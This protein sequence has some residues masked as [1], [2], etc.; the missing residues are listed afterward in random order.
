MIIRQLY[1]CRQ[2]ENSN[3]LEEPG[4]KVPSD[5]EWHFVKDSSYQA[6]DQV[7]YICVVVLGVAAILSFGGY[8]SIN[9]SKLEK[10]WSRKLLPLMF[11]LVLGLST[12]V[13]C[14]SPNFR[15]SGVEVEVVQIP[16][17]D[18]VCA[19]PF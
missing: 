2:D 19:T 9:V 1:L 10:T 7:C 14:A 15:G 11:F 18:K 3:E 8:L 6:K 4:I 16:E 13:S 12:T 5:I 17:T